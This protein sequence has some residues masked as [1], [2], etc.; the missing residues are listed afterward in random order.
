MRRERVRK[1]IY[2]STP[3]PTDDLTTPS[4]FRSDRKEA[5]ETIDDEKE[6]EKLKDESL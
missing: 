4:K 6:T 3:W 2:R 5:R 1:K